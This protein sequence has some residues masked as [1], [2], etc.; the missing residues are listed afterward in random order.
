MRQLNSL[1]I[2]TSL[3]LRTINAVCLLGATYNHLSIM[4][5]YGL[6]WDYGGKPWPTAAFWTALTFIDPLAAALLFVRPNPGVLMTLA[7]ML[8]DVPHNLWLTARENP[9][10]LPAVASQP[11]VMEQIA[12]PIFVL[13]TFRLA[14]V[15]H[16]SL[17]TTWTQT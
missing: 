17:R 2:T 4:L 10:L 6:F 11:M 9:S 14:R 13:A 7:I 16:Y 8:V 5:R 1:A 3:T 12:F 15:H